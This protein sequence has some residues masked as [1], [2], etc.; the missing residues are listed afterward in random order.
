MPFY[1][2]PDGNALRLYR[3]SCSHPNQDTPRAYLRALYFGD[4]DTANI[5]AEAT[6]NSGNYYTSRVY[7]VHLVLER[8]FINQPNDP[9]LEL[10]YVADLLGIGEAKRIAIRFAKYIEETD[11]W[12]YTINPG[13]E[14]SSVAAYVNSDPDAVKYLYFQAHRFFDSF[15]EINRL[16]RLGYDGAIHRGS[17]S[18]SADATEYCV[19]SR[20]QVYFTASKT[21]LGKD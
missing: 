3:G 1:K 16:R 19:F 13:G 15:M 14:W 5:Y 7:P 10:G 2:G 18:G 12:Q 6:V 4:V 8:P 21:F 11:N 9:F 20:S 17:G